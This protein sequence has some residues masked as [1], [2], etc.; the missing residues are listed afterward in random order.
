M[1]EHR[2]AVSGVVVG[3][4][5][6]R[7][8]GVRVAGDRHDV[9]RLALGQRPA[10]DLRAAADVVEDRGRRRRA[11]D[12][13]REAREPAAAQR[14]Q[15]ERGRGSRGRAHRDPVAAVDLLG[16]R[17][18]V[19]AERAQLLGDPLR[20]LALARRGGAALDRLQVPDGG[21]RVGHEA[22]QASG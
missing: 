19:G 16:L 15:R 4:E 8:V 13:R 3:H 1:V 9:A 11:A 14:Q 5:H 21:L 18:R 17:V 10:R 12:E 6:E 7:A 2:S 20:R 22:P